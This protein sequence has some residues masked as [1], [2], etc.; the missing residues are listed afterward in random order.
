MA[1]DAGPGAGRVVALTVDTGDSKACERALAEAEAALGAPDLL[2]NGVGGKA[3][4][5]V[6]TW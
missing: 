1:K 3:S 2:L 6:K 5:D 4:D